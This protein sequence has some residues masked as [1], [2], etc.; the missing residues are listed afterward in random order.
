MGGLGS[1]FVN[2]NK[3]HAK[4]EISQVLTY[5]WSLYI[6]TMYYEKTYRNSLIL[7]PARCLSG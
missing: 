5:V 3:P 1:H 7:G 6:T 4:R 2:L